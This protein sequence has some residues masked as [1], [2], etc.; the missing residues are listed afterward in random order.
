[1]TTIENQPGHRHIAEICAIHGLFREQLNGHC[2][3]QKIADARHEL[4]FRLVILEGFS[5]PKA[6]RIRGTEYHHTSVL[7]G[8]RKVASETLNTP[9]EATLA[10]IREAWQ[11]AQMGRAA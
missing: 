6:G 5:L 8:V 9:Y 2:K 4:W 3:T 11:T 10:Q 1:M 7:H